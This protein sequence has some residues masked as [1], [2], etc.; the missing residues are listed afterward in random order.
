[1][2]HFVGFAYDKKPFV[3]DF[4]KEKLIDFPILPNAFR[5]GELHY[6]SELGQ[7]RV[8]LIDKSGILQKAIPREFFV[9]NNNSFSQLRS[10]ISNIINE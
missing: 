2:F 7:G 1:M 8:F 5:L 10:L 3:D 4:Q 9:D 6:G